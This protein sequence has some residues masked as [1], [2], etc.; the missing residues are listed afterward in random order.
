MNA[1]SCPPLVLAHSSS[2]HPCSAHHAWAAGSDS[3]MNARW[4][5]PDPGSTSGA[6]CSC[7]SSTIT[8]PHCPYADE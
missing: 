2:G 4:C 3:T 1:N 6:V 7:T 8:E 5:T